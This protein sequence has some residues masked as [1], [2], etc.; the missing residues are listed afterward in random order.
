MNS[1][2]TVIAAIFIV[3][4]IVLGA[5]IFYGEESGGGGSTLE[6]FLDLTDTPGS[7]TGSSDYVV[8]VNA[9][10]T[11]LT[12]VNSGSGGLQLTWFKYISDSGS[13]EATAVE[14]V[15]N[16]LGGTNIATAI[17]GKTLDIS[18]DITSSVE[19]S[20][21]DLNAV[22]SL[23]GNATYV[24]VGTGTT[25]HGLSDADDFLVSDELEV[26]AVAWLDGGVQV[27]GISAFDGNMTVIGD[28]GLTG[29]LT[30]TNSISAPAFIGASLWNLT[31]TDT[32][33]NN[34]SAGVNEV[35]TFDGTDWGP[36]VPSVAAEDVSIVDTYSYYNPGTNVEAALDLL[37]Q[38]SQETLSPSGFPNTT[39]STFSFDD[40]SRTFSITPV[41]GTFSYYID[42]FRYVVSGTDSV[43]ITD[44]EGLHVI[45][46]DGGT[47]TAVYNPNHDQLENA[48]LSTALVAY[49]YWDDDNNTNRL[50]EER[51]GIVMSPWTHLWIHESTG[52][53]YAYG[54]A[55]SDIQADQSGDVNS[56]A[57]FGVEAGEIYDEDL[58]HNLTAVGS[59]SGLEIYYRN[60]GLD[61]MRWAT[62]A[63]YSVLTTGTG[64]LA[65]DN[66]GTLTEVANGD[67]VL[68]HVFATN[69]V[70]LKPIVLVG[71][72][73]YGNVISA[74]QGA[75]VEINNIIIDEIISPEMHPIASVIF[76][77]RDSY[78][79]AVKARIRT[80]DEG[81][82]YVDWRTAKLTPGVGAQDHGALSGLQDNDHSQYEA[83]NKVIADSGSAT[84]D[85]NPDTLTISGGTNVATSITG[86]TLTIS[87]TGA[88]ASGTPTLGEV[89]EQGNTVSTTLDMNSFGIANASTIAAFTLDGK[90]TG[91]AQ[92][93]EGSNFD[94]NGGDVSALTV[95]GGLTWNAAQDF[96]NQN[97]T[98]VDINSGSL[99]GVIIGANNPG[100]AAFT[101]AYITDGIFGAVVTDTFSLSGTTTITVNGNV[102][103][104]PSE[105]GTVALTG[106]FDVDDFDITGPGS[107][108]LA[109]TSYSIVLTPGGAIIP[110][111]GG[112]T[113]AMTDGTNHSYYTL[114]FASGTLS[115]CYWDFE[116]PLTYT[117]GNIT[118]TISW[119]GTP[120]TGDVVW[121]A[122][123]VGVADS[124]QYDVAL[125]GTVSV[126]TTIDSTTN[127]VNTS[128]F[129]AFDPGWDAGDIVVWQFARSSS[130][131]MTGDAH[132]IMA[133]I[134]WPSER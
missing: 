86:D 66:G 102:I 21:Q 124:E 74:R 95:S 123:T 99:D 20:G 109:D 52:T 55:L 127:D 39:D 69:N 18:F 77:T 88:G 83:F 68:C 79:N 42:G 120:T 128:T 2:F 59:A 62:N 46:Y 14:D 22:D 125:G 90:L 110:T 26:N 54:L 78:G 35:L 50:M 94:I 104:F 64:R 15:L 28:I 23:L 53:T 111:S 105:S 114:S 87:Y 108:S 116:I 75:E 24:R 58:R 122:S 27:T 49:V 45:Y 47:L 51:H 76:Q 43:A 37:A 4:V 3:I 41:S 131:S 13:V 97:L 103:A 5:L 6:S 16:V 91:G 134:S 96:N 132:M 107:V 71:Q 80:T 129:S 34:A 48:I 63:G 44:D 57:Q 17:S 84:A 7:Y 112:P 8:A 67:F 82:D 81:A 98:N 29:G 60:T 93:I 12:F 118:P 89:M 73:T 85:D 106:K 92:E 100:S 33:T 30:S 113:Q 117:G 115:K 70:E 36:A 11:G 130:T 121:W 10:S 61:G 65:W 32:G 56:H 72:S 9:T 126:T 25:S 40:A 133:E 119:T 19:M 31:D 101:T 38:N 1:S